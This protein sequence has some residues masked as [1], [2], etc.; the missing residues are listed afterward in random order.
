MRLRSRLTNEQI[1][2]YEKAKVVGS[3][4]KCGVYAWEIGNLVVYD[5]PKKLSEFGIKHAPQSW[6]YCEELPA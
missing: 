6:C 2:K 1:A 3:T 4:L 5:N